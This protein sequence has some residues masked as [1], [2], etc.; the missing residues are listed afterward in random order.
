[1]IY[2][3]SNQPQCQWFE[4]DVLGSLINEATLL[5]LLLVKTVFRIYVRKTRVPSTKQ[6]SPITDTEAYRSQ[7][8]TDITRM[9]KRQERARPL[10][11]RPDLS[12]RSQLCG[13][14]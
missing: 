3:Q 9:R 4:S 7:L 14:S 10:S 12:I 11:N 13:D 1:M 5:S 2:G 8:F 6:K